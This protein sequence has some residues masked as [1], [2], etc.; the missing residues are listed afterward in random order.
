MR[1]SNSGSAECEA[2]DGRTLVGGNHFRLSKEDVSW[3]ED[4][5]KK[6]SRSNI[7]KVT[8]SD[9]IRDLIREAREEGY[10]EA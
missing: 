7:S 6:L 4:T 5:A 10:G 2:E 1:E 9:L 3:L 8:K